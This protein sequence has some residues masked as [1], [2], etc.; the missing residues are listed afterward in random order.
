M[1]K[2]VFV[3]GVVQSVGFRA[4]TRQQARLYPLLRGWVRNLPDGRVEAVFSGALP[5]V[6]AM[7]EWCRHGPSSAVVEKIEILSEPVDS[8]LTSFK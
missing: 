2:R 1:Q 4:S 8:S 6:D 5:E 3:T 7:V